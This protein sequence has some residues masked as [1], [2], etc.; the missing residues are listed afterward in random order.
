MLHQVRP[1]P[2]RACSTLGSQWV[3]HSLRHRVGVLVA[4]RVGSGR[5]GVST[6]GAAAG[7][8]RWTAAYHRYQGGVNM[9]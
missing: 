9:A 4:A 2:E 6:C 8:L 3:T 1:N 7:H 5:I